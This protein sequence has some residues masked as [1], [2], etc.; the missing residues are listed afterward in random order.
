MRIQYAPKWSAR[1]CTYDG[2]G[3]CPS[4]TFPHDTSNIP[5]RHIEHSFTIHQTFPRDPSNIPSQRIQHSLATHWTFPHDASNI[6]SWPIKH[7]LMTRSAARLHRHSL[8]V[9]AQFSI[10]I[11]WWREDKGDTAIHSHDWSLLWCPQCE[12]SSRGKDEEEI[13]LSSLLYPPWWKIQGIIH[14]YVHTVTITYQSICFVLLV[15]GNRL[16]QIPRWTG[17]RSVGE[18]GIHKSWEKENLP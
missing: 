3:G 2:P 17:E 15:A 5:S 4:Q 13:I 10:A 7:F 14:M 11:H 1:T 8:H 18:A 6:P 12:K 9:H 16:S